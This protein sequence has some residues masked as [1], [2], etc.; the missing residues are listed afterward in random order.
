MV[1]PSD[2]KALT[3]FAKPSLLMTESAEDFASLT[4]LLVQ[5]IKPRGI[6]ERI[7]VADI[8][9]HVWEILRLRRCKAVIVNTAFKEA[10][11]DLL[12]RLT[13]TPE[14]GSSKKIEREALV[15][16][17]FSHPKA[18]KEVSEILAKYQL[19]EF[20]IEAEAIRIRSEDLD[21][22]DSMLTSAESLRNKTLRRIADDRDRFAKQVREVSDQL[23]EGQAVV[24]LENRSARR[25]A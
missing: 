2:S 19:D 12:D 22:L 1:R 23:I 7:Y 14:W 3:L 24:Q 18:K 6:I 20:A 17:W 16:D 25:S 9:H 13:G 10:L 15:R 8:A 5:E 11:L 21:R 4:A